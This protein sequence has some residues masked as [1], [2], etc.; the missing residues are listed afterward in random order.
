MERD[1]LERQLKVRFK[2]VDERVGHLETKAKG[3]E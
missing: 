1:K 2:G 3:G